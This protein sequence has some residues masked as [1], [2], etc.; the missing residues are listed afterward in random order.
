MSFEP[1]CLS[2]KDIFIK[3]LKLFV[4]DLPFTEHSIKGAYT[5]AASRIQLAVLSLPDPLKAVH[6]EYIQS[7]SAQL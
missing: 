2:T 3:V 1:F 7:H 4:L 5:T 6:G